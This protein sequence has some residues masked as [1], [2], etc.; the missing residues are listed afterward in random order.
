MRLIDADELKKELGIADDC[1]QC[2]HARTIF[3]SKG[4]N[5]VDACEAINDAPT[6]ESLKRLTIKI[7]PAQVAERLRGDIYGMWVPSDEMVPDEEV[8]VLCQTITKK[9]AI[10]L[11]IGYYADGRWCCGMN[12]N[13]VAWMPLP[14]PYREERQQ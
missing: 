6:I 5:F 8:R 7:D 3:C 11:V 2:D 9:G 13:V 14:E 1:S 10:N 12:S 4:S